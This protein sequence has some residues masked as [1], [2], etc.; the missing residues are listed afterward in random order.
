MAGYRVATLALAAVLLL[1]G[2]GATPFDREGSARNGTLTPAPV[3]AET[4]PPE[5]APGLSE[6]RVIDHG[7]FEAAYRATA[8]RERVSLRRTRTIYPAGATPDVRGTPT[9]PRNVTLGRNGSYRR[10]VVRSTL[11]EPDRRYLFSSIETSSRAVAGAADFSRVDIWFRDGRVRNRLV[12]DWGA[13]YWQRYSPRGGGPIRDPTRGSLVADD[14]RAFDFRVA[15]RRTV[16]GETRYRLVGTGYR[17]D[18]VE[19]SSSLS[20]RRNGR[21]EAV[22]TGSGLVRRYR[23][24]YDAT[25][26]NRSVTVVRTHAVVETGVTRLPR[27]D[28]LAAGNWSAEPERLRRGGG[29]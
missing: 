13:R 17:P 21:L 19:V 24:S 27:P 11:V 16:D 20:E 18:R 15:G 9:T 2:C 10:V 12:G 14:L 22:V 26:R 5:I 28:W 23:L 6:R 25:F 4:G 29:R 8:E 3:P 1:A 7:R